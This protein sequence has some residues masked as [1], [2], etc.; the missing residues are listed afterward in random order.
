MAKQKIY[1]VDGSGYIFR[2]YYAIAPLSTREGFPTNALLGFTRMMLKLLQQAGTDHVVV[3]FDAGRE[4]FRTELYSEYKANRDECPE[5]LLKQ[6]PYFKEIACALGLPVFELKGYEAD[7]ILGTLADR[8]VSFGEE[9]VVVSGDKD[10]MQLVNDQVTIW[11]TMKDRIYDAAGVKEKMG[12]EPEK[13]A[14]NKT[15][16]RRGEQHLALDGKSLRG[17]VTVGPPRQAA[18]QL[19]GLYH[20]TQQYVLRQVTVSGLGQERKMALRLIQQVNLY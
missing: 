18:V 4:T 14:S 12:V 5:D 1:L 16:V 7:D 20:V 2:A 13:V 9:V 19:L 8:L 17:T 11:D 15:A 6:M 10:L 3:T